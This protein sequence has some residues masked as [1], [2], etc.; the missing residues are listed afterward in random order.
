MVCLGYCG[1][2]KSLFY[3]AMLLFELLFSRLIGKTMWNVCKLAF[4]VSYLEHWVACLVVVCLAF[5]LAPPAG[6][7]AHLWIRLPFC[8]PLEKVICT[9]PR[10]M[11]AEDA[12]QPRA[13]LFLR[14]IERTMKNLL[15]LNTKA[16]SRRR[17][18]YTKIS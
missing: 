13:H 4:K 3:R 8:L 17:I 10:R 12:I 11:L 18:Y 7:F 9:S 15:H 5:D 16:I 1:R 14:Q 6:Y 2:E